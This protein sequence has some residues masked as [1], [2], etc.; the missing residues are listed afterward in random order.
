MS[1]VL[2]SQKSYVNKHKTSDNKKIILDNEIQVLEK[3]IESK[4]TESNNLT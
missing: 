4:K 2:E 1:I 3:Q